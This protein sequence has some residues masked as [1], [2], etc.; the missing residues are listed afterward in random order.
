[1]YH[2]VMTYLVAVM[3]RTGL[4]WIGSDTVSVSPSADTS[5]TL[6]RQMLKKTNF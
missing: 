6:S 3:D 4:E 1:M 2:V 5:F